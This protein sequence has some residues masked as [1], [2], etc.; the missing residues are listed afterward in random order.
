MQ[1]NSSF[2]YKNSNSYTSGPKLLGFILL[3]VGVFVLLSPFF[4]SSGSSLEKT[5]VIGV[6]ALIIGGILATMSSGIFVDF[7]KKRWR[8]Y[9]SVL[10]FRLGNWQDLP[11][12]EKADLVV[13]QFRGRNTPN[14]ITPTLSGKLTLH[15]CVLLTNEE[16]YLVFDYSKGKN[17]I[18]ALE[19]LKR[20]LDL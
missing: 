13:H 1:P 14:G 19:E 16:A 10:G 20:G 17:A 12:I 9:D 3:T 5:M 6:L 4:I 8:N 15:K 2:D 7:N 11:K 18:K